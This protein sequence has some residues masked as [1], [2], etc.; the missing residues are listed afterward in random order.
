M[1]ITTIG[2]DLAKAVFQIHGVD[3]RGK[4]AVRKQLKRAEMSSYF[5]ILETCLIGMQARGSVHYWA[6][7]LDW[8]TLLNSIHYCLDRGVHYIAMQYR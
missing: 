2:I 4:V 6:K 5:A 7:K 8:G 1:K 3:E